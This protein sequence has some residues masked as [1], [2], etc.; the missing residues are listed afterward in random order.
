MANNEY[1]EL[2]DKERM[3]E[4][5][6]IIM[7]RNPLRHDGHAY[8]YELCGWALG[9]PE[10]PQKPKPEDFGQQPPPP[11]PPTDGNPRPSRQNDDDDGNDGVKI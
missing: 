4:A 9:D 10:F 1:Y 8:E 6:T 7:D 3:R 11:L 5:L 2:L